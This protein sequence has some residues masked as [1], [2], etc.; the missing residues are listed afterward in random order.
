MEVEV[1]EPIADKIVL[2]QGYIIHHANAANSCSSVKQ[3]EEER[4]SRLESLALCP[5]KGRKKGEG[6]GELRKNLPQ[7]LERDKGPLVHAI[8]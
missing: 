1:R 3:K 6:V 4:M 5:E 8:E 2:N 7:F